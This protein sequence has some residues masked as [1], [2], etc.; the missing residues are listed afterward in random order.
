MKRADHFA[1]NDVLLNL[2]IG[3]MDEYACSLNLLFY[4]GSV[5]SHSSIGLSKSITSRR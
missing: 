3:A 1:F 4:K 2:A 5:L